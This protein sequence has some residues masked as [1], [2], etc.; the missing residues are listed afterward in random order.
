LFWCCT[1]SKC[2][3]YSRCNKITKQQKTPNLSINIRLDDILTTVFE[4]IRRSCS[5]HVHNTPWSAWILNHCNI[6]KR[7]CECTLTPRVERHFV[8]TITCSTIWIFSHDFLNPGFCRTI[9]INVNRYH[10]CEQIFTVNGVT[11]RVP[12]VAQELITRLEFTPVICGVRVAQMFGFQ[13]SGLYIIVLFCD[14]YFY[15]LR[16][17]PSLEYLFSIFYRLIHDLH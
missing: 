3:I 9:E 1:F 15:F 7:D 8:T 14:H 11:R 4:W 13:Y 12:P 16:R 5:R 17:F 10:H 6:Y 2:I